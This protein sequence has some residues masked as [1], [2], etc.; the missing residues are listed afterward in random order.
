MPLGLDEVPR[1]HVAASFVVTLIVACGV[2]PDTIAPPNIASADFQDGTIGDFQNNEPPGKMQIID[3]PTGAGLGKVLR[4][5]YNLD[6]SLNHDDDNAGLE[7]YFNRAD[8]V[9]DV[10]MRTYVYIA[11]PGAFFDSLN[12]QRKI[13]YV[14]PG[15]GTWTATSSR[16]LDGISGA[17]P[18]YV[19]LRMV[20]KTG[21]PGWAETEE[22]GYIDWAL[23]TWY[24]LEMR[25]KLNTPGRSNGIVQIW[26]GPRGAPGL[27]NMLWVDL[28]AVD[29]RAASTDPYIS[30]IIGQQLDRFGNVAWT[31]NRYLKNV[32][33][34][35]T[36]I[37]P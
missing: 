30:V 20:A 15:E 28:H 32:A 21:P 33:L 26:A 27:A 24:Y 3:D 37:G 4:I 11:D 13:I 8:N 14:N 22:S 7:Y 36:R 17:F 5:Q 23:G 1:L 6:A 34:S 25:V 29:V 19:G 10:Y 31:E 16:Y 35:T 9:Q 12:A 2:G 18:Q